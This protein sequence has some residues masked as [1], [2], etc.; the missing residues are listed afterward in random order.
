MSERQA[1]Q[2]FY[3]ILEV[4]H[5]AGPTEIYN[6]Y[7]RARTTYSPTSPALY[8]MFSPE[9]A[10]E[11]LA[12]IEEAY[13]TLSHQAKRKEYDIRLG[14][15]PAGAPPRSTAV[16]P[17]Q[18]YSAQE[19]KKRI[20]ENWVGPVKV[21]RPLA[22]A[23]DLPQGFARTKF[24]VY[25][26]NPD[27]EK[28]IEAVEE[29]DGAFLQKMRMYR[30]VSLEQLA[31]EI[32]VTKTT[33]NALEGNDIEALP[34]PVFTRGFVVGMTRALGLDEKKI[35]DAYMKFFKAKKSGK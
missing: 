13:Q 34:V 21:L 7:Q 6:A 10:Q 22:K 18:K 25:E 9:E 2:T 5:S 23:E 17:A 12:L 33:L 20:D 4:P 14:L 26:I 15:K 31:E 27:L 28:E 32:R 35:T 11:L 30:G 8:S 19:A 24:S 1:N 3:E 29:C 16:E